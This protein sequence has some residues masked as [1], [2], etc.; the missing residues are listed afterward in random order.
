M[1][2]FDDFISLFFPKTCYACG[3]NL[4]TGE[5]IICTS[6]LVHLPKTHFHNDPNN[7]LSKI[8]WGRVKIESATSLYF[9]RKGGKVQ[10][11]IHQFKYKGHQEIGIYLGEL[12]GRDLEQS[13]GFS[14]IDSIIP[15]PLHEK[16]IRKRGFNQSEIFAKGLADSMKKELDTTSVIR[17]VATTTQTKKSRYKRWE[18]VKEIFV[19]SN[20]ERL[21]GKHI[22][23]V[24]DVITT[25]ATMEACI[26]ALLQAP[27]VRVSVASIACTQH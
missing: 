17:T 10:H 14:S 26:Q 18:N 1:S 23:L 9:F 24:D 13:N 19:I 21:S 22:L 4:F 8:F 16:K 3:N 6:C 20:V 15:V 25:G 5:R 2:L 11:L 27:G 7:P 12:L